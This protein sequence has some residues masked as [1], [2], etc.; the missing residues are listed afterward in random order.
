MKLLY[1]DLPISISLVRKRS[2]KRTY[3]I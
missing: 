2:C 1:W 3:W